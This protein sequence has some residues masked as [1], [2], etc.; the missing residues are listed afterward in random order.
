MKLIF[1]FL[2]SI[3]ISNNSFSNEYFN[4]L[5]LFNKRK[6]SDSV[7]LFKQVADDEKIQKEAMLC[8][9]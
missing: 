2:I 1:T 8:T 9:I 6:I 5:E 7:I 4:A 3:L